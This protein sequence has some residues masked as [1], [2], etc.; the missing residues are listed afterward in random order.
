MH[1]HKAG[2]GDKQPS[3]V[4]HRWTQAGES[5]PNVRWWG[6][7]WPRI[8]RRESGARDSLK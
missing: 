1:S 6:G 3:Q 5:P 2:A 4:K 8:R 7:L